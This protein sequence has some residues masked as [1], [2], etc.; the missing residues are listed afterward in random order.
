VPDDLVLGGLD[1]SD[2]YDVTRAKAHAILTGFQHDL[3][4]NTVRLPVNYPTVSGPYWASYAGAIDEARRVRMNVVLSYWES[5]ASKDG[6]VDDLAQFWSMWRIIVDKYGRDRRV[7]FEPMNEPHGY[8]D[9]EWRDLAAEWLRRYPNV[10]RSRVIVSGAGYNQRGAP[11]GADPRFAACLISVHIYGFW[12]RDWT[13]RQP[14]ETAIDASVGPYANRTL[15]TEFGAPMTTGLDYNRGP[16]NINGTAGAF[17]AFMQGVPDR[18]RELG[19]GTI[20]WPGLRIGDPY[21]LETLHGAG[22]HLSLTVN[23]RSGLDR[24][25]Y[26]W[27]RGIRSRSRR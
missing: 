2:T 23:N 15:L 27:S 3:G 22:T 18:A 14:W 13:S 9:D 4:A 19:I 25:R 8:A 24:L 17:L 7:Y 16:I 10:P 20:Y 1:T 5:S 6:K 21:S 12:H 26:S 11:I